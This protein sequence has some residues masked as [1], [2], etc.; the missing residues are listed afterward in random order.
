[1]RLRC[2]IQVQL[3]KQAGFQY[4]SGGDLLV[5][6]YHIDQSH[7]LSNCVVTLTD[8]AH[9]VHI[10][11]VSSEKS[12]FEYADEIWRLATSPVEKATP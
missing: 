2:R 1:M 5:R 4:T 11:P 6:K 8:S 12:D 10:V 9:D 7:T 3:Y